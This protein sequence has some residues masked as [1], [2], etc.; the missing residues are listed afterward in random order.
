MAILDQHG[1]KLPDIQRVIAGMHPLD[2]A[3]DFLD[4]LRAEE[5]VIILSDT[6]YQFAAPLLRQLGQPT[7]FCND[8]VTDAEGR[9]VDYRLRVPDGKRRA[10]V[11][12]REIGFDVR[13]GGDSY[14]DT[15]M[16]SAANRGV[17]FRCPDNV[18][19]EF[20]QFRRTD[21]YEELWQS[22]LE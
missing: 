7:L 21:T 15:S 9:V 19:R 8:L 2:G 17:L 4:R 5:Q 6:F 1:L 13:A 11:S 18:A 16:L 12:L 10:V 3:R 20:P 14:N 22:L